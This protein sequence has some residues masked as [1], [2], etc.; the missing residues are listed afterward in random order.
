[1]VFLSENAQSSCQCLMNHLSPG[2][3]GL[4]SV[5]QAFE[6]SCKES[7]PACVPATPKDHGHGSIIYMLDVYR[8]R[9]ELSSAIGVI[10][11]LGLMKAGSGRPMSPSLVAPLGS[12]SPAIQCCVFSHRCGTLPCTASMRMSQSRTQ[13]KP[14]IQKLPRKRQPQV[15]RHLQLQSKTN[16]LSPQLAKPKAYVLPTGFQCSYCLVVQRH[17]GRFVVHGPQMG[18]TTEA[19]T[20]MAHGSPAGA[21]QYVEQDLRPDS[22]RSLGKVVVLDACR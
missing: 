10:T 2:L 12:R 4:I 21:A 17:E 11:C 22:G 3:Y 1:M 7:Y 14:A 19:Y 8:I 15:I 20:P 16:P 18:F 9:K 5:P 6:E 13:E